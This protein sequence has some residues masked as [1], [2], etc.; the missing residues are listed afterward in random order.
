MRWHL[1]VLEHGSACEQHTLSIGIAGILSRA[2]TVRRGDMARIGVLCP[3]LAGHLNPMLVL[4]RELWRRGHSIVFWQVADMKPRIENEGFEFECVGA[5]EYPVGASKEYLEKLGE[6]K[7]TSVIRFWHAEHEKMSEVIC[8]D[9]SISIGKSCVDMMLV[10]QV[11]PAGQAVAEHTNT[12]FLTVCNAL[13]L[14]RESAV[15]PV[16]SSFVYRDSKISRLRNAILYKVGDQAVKKY[17]NS[18]ARIRESW[19]LRKLSDSELLFAT[20]PLAH[21]SQQPEA[22]DFPRRN[23]PAR[24]HY[25]GPFREE[26]KEEYGFPF[27]KLNGKPIVY[28]SLGTLQNRK[29]QIFEMI[30]ETCNH[31]DVQLVIA[32][33]GGV[34]A[35]TLRRLSGTALV[36]AYAPQ[37]QVIARAALVITHAGLNTVLDALSY[38][39]PMVAI[40]IAFEQPAIAARIRWAGVGEMIPAS[41]LN[42]KRLRNLIRRV[43]N[44]ESYTISARKMRDAIAREDGASAAANVIESFLNH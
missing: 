39:V 33:G 8:R 36:V 24:F 10:D 3:Q 14:N 34:D 35:A 29:Q 15:P 1:D 23:L 28:A 22:F 4:A 20:S 12:P 2:N 17:S 42:G 7:G 5:L 41:K 18:L 37:C 27:D 11:E 16:F 32:H 30:A 44:G 9:I 38:G 21:I 13:L 43:L 19:G 26:D 25:C 31:F 40:P 6:L